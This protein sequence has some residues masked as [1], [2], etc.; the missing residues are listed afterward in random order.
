M[1]GRYI[2]V[3]DSFKGCL[4]SRRVADAVTGALLKIDSSADVTAVPVSDGGEGMLD[5]V[6]P[7]VGADIVSCR[8]F[9]PLMRR[10]DVSYGIHGTTAYIESALACGISLLKTEELNPLVATTY[11]L[12][13]VV[14]DAVSR[15]CK[16]IVVGLGGS[17]TC[18]AGMGMLKAVNDKFSFA[19]HF[20]DEVRSR[21]RDVR[22]TIL[23]D[24]VNPLLGSNGAARVFAPQKGASADDVESLEWRISKFATISA[25]HF[26]YD[27]SAV[28]SAGAAGGLGYAFMQYFGAEVRSGAD[29]ILD[30][31]HFDDIVSGA[32][33][34]IT[35]EGSADAQTLMGKLPHKV[36]QR[37]SSVPVHL[38]AGQVSD[39]PSLLAAGFAGVHC[40]SPA[41]MP[42]ADC[43]LPQNACANIERTV[44]EVF[45]R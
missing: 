39:A 30:L 36:L 26:G 11:G 10:I 20:D 41:D 25:R 45:G 43:M 15:G 12:G 1:S 14:A 35:G 34:V 37:S 8:S 17:A 7:V 4:S 2:V 6:A 44:T 27:R 29:F 13:V 38:F 31:C 28:P 21:L 9:D 19:H 33:A 18:D 5:A 23:A 40:I 42:L 22:F 32:A 16:H 3:P 24:V